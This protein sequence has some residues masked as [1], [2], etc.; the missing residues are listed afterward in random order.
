MDWTTYPRQIPRKGWAAYFAML[1]VQFLVTTGL[2]G[3]VTAG[4]VALVITVLTAT[5]IASIFTWCYD[6]RLRPKPE[7]EKP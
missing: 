6:V 7:K 2:S 3:D 1:V 4:V 5:V